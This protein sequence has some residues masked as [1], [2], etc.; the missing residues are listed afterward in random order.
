MCTPFPQ[1]PSNFV[2]FIPVGGIHPRGS[3]S[4]NA[5][6]QCRPIDSVEEVFH[7]YKFA[8]HVGGRCVSECHYD[9][10]VPGR[11]ANVPI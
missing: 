4:R 10:F 1:G 2:P 7:L 8:A 9:T 6:G 3:A 5:I 11:V